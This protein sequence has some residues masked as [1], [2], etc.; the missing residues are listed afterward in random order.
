M[1][2]G[3]AQLAATDGGDDHHP[4]R[5]RTHRLLWVKPLGTSVPRR[6]AASIQLLAQEDTGVARERESDPAELLVAVALVK[7]GGLES[8][9]LH[10]RPL[11]AAPLGFLLDGRKE[12]APQRPAA[13]VLR[14][15]AAARE[16]WDF[17]CPD[18][19]ERLERGDAM[20]SRQRAMSL[21]LVADVG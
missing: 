18:W 15:V 21:R 16:G 3:L 20:E 19:A 7:A 4:R 2:R 10:D 12:A 14:R 13:D 5:C 1:V 6:A 9:R 11:A 17:S 8:A